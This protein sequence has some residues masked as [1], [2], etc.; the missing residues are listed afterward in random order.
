MTRNRLSVFGAALALALVTSGCFGGGGV[1]TR[2]VL[3]DF[4]HDQFKSLFLKYFPARIQAHP[5]D[6][7]L[8]RQSWTGEVH[9]VTGGTLADAVGKLVAP[10]LKAGEP[11][12]PFGAP[13]EIQKAVDRIGSPF[14]ET[15]INQTIAQ[16]CYLRSGEP[17]KNGEP[18][19]DRAQPV[20]DGREAVY[21]SGVIPY[22][23][24]QGNEFGVR[25]SQDIRP[26]SYF[27][28]CVT[29]GP[30]QSTFVEVK[31]KQTAIPS[32]EEI[33]RTARSEIDKTASPLLSAF[34]TATRTGKVE[35]EG[36]ELEGPFAGLFVPDS[37]A[38]VNEFIPA[39]LTVKAGE[40]VTWKVLGPPHTIS[41]NV[42]KY[43]PIVTFRKDGTVVQNPRI[44]EPAGGA[45]SFEQLDDDAPTFKVDAGTYDGTG[46]WSS[47]GVVD[48]L[49]VDYTLRFSRPG[50]YRFACLVHPPMVGTLTVL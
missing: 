5:G 45:P 48:D 12:A 36:R 7:I 1:Q 10:L 15:G 18:C 11:I 30:Q 39:K 29:H 9:T 19:P 3:V 43:F 38:L 20:F 6:R 32:A 25:L 28:F 27:F 21:N 26:G 4:T 40:P 31:P 24:Q 22:E 42:P 50:T 47:G 17:A 37:L 13:P 8:F 23:G 41:F 14:N 33:S 16:P 44:H 34:R 46:F 35:L 49:W 2:T